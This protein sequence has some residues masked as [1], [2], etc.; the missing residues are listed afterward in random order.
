MDKAQKDLLLEIMEVS[1]ALVE[2]G[3]YLNTHPY[4]EKALR[5][6]NNSSAAYRELV[7]MYQSKYGP[8]TYTGMSN[9]PWSYIESPWPWEINFD[10]N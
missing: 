6:H 4:D 2:T 7:D 8:L 5:Y 1:F 3:L 9:Y 10:N